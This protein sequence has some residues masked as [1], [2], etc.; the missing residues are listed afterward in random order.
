MAPP[1]QFRA[2]PLRGLTENT[3]QLE[4]PDLMGLGKHSKIC[5]FNKYSDGANTG[6]QI[7]RASVFKG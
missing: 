7:L 2:A 6:D 5:S 1:D 3:A 4:S